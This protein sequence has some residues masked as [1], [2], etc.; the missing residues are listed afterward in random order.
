MKTQEIKD[1]LEYLRG[2]IEAERISY[3]EIH[4]LQN[5]AAHIDEEDVQLLQ[6]AGVPEFPEQLPPPSEGE[7]GQHSPIPWADA[8]E[9]EVAYSI[10]DANGIVLCDV[11][12]N[13][14]GANS[15]FIVKAVNHHDELVAALRELNAAITELQ[16]RLSTGALDRC[17]TA[18]DVT[19]ALLTKL[20]AHL[21]EQN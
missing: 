6:W 19:E 3:G 10:E 5:L 11:H 9:G 1:R 21:C 20:E 4:E 15:A 16:M 18:Q 14:G 2:E 7:L 8:T 12:L 17:S 13:T